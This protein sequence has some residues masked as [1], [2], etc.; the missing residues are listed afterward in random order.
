M[1]EVYQAEWCP[2]SRMV[3]ER[4]GEL[5]LPFVARPV[6]ADRED[7]DALR[8]LSG[9]DTIPVVVLEDGT[10]LAGDTRETL[11]ELDRRFEEPPGAEAHRRALAGHGGI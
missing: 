1:I 2:Y 5:D 3:R 4:L 7:R 11:A 6:P 9:S 8:E 10:V